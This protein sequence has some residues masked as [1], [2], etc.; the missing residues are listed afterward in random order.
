VNPDYDLLERLL[1]DHAAARACGLLT[2]K[3]VFPFPL[4]PA[5]P[6]ARRRWLH[7]AAT[8]AVGFALAAG[9][10]SFLLS[11]LAS[12]EPE[13]PEY[14][15][16]PV[17][18]APGSPTP[19]DVPAQ[20]LPQ[21]LNGRGQLI[22]TSAATRYTLVNA[23][24]GQVRLERGELFVEL[25]EDTEMRAD[26]ETPVGT[27]TA[28]GTRF[29]AH[30][31]ETAAPPRLPFL[32]IAVLG[33]FVEVRNA[34]GRAL[35]GAGEV[36]L[37]DGESAPMRHA[38][39]PYLDKASAPE[40]AWWRFGN[41]LGTFT[42]PEV[43]AD[44]KITDAQKVRLHRP[45]SDDQRTMGQFFRDLYDLPPDVRPRQAGAF[46]GVQE[47]RIADVLDA[48]QQRRLGQIV[49]QQQGYAALQY[50]ELADALSLMEGQRRRVDAVVKE[51]NSVRRPGFARGGWVAPE[52]GKRLDELRRQ[53]GEKLEALLTDA[54]KEQWRTLIGKPLQ[55][56]RRPNDGRFWWDG[57]NGIDGPDRWRAPEQGPPWQWG[58]NGWR[59]R[60]PF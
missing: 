55:M 19:N 42:R 36:V 17:A 14:G 47:K 40:R 57:G 24:H 41:V 15:S 16:A 21:F 27:A 10:A 58:P 46:R 29:F 7:V 37:A 49:L 31:E 56:E 22:P 39:A 25:P 26:I 34:H 6:K 38:G 33:G 2:E 50:P 4:P 52:A 48:A 53:E 35:A 44:L 20:E 11:I 9:L 28:L 8:V 51:F 12:R 30:Y 5:Q 1:A 32:T 18:D 23:A 59:G 60:Q 45:S 43:Q 54:Q 3:R 13:Q